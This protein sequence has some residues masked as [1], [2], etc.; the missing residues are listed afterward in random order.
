[1]RRSPAADEPQSAPRGDTGLPD[2]LKSGVESLSGLSL[3]AVRVHYNSSQPSDVDAHAFTQGTDIHV[4]PGQERHLPHEAWHAVQQAQGRVQ[5]TGELRGAVPVNDDLG[6][7]QEAEAMGA[8]ASA[9]P[10]QR[11]PGQRTL[12][13]V[14]AQLGT[15][16]QRVLAHTHPIVAVEV[17]SVRRIPGKLV[18]ILDGGANGIVVVKFETVGRATESVARF[19]DRQTALRAI[20]AQVLQNVPGASSLDAA[21]MGAIAQINAAG[22]ADLADLKMMAD[23]VL[24]TRQGFDRLLALKMENINVGQNLEDM[25]RAAAQAA[26]AAPAPRPGRRSRR[27]R[28]GACPRAGPRADRAP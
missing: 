13:P 19:A 14:V 15:P 18:F 7:E 9:T 22:G 27:P 2:E 11:Q 3:D 21:D 12:D 20:A 16:I 25:V 8:K 28:A 10:A 26:A 6:L 23:G 17:A 24:N 5:P 4:A 1:M